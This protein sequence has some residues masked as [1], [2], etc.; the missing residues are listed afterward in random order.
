MPL[1]VAP[2][3]GVQHHFSYNRIEINWR[4]SSVYHLRRIWMNCVWVGQE[5]PDRA[6]FETAA[7]LRTS[8][9]SYCTMNHNT[10][11]Q[12][13][14]LLASF[15]SHFY[16]MYLIISLTITDLVTY[17]ISI[18]DIWISLLLWMLV[19]TV[20]LVTPTTS[21]LLNQKKTFD[22]SFISFFYIPGVS[23]SL[24]GWHYEGCP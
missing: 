5:R 3:Y 2:S 4:R 12:P 18:A 15:H 24:I 9:S 11:R 21:S 1:L 6:S 7:R 10:H 22:N 13:N 16:Y 17:I 14:R 23:Y 19:S 8:P 20:K